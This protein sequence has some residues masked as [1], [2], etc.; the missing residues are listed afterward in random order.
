MCSVVKPLTVV[1]GNWD[2]NPRPSHSDI[3]CFSFENWSQ[4][5]EKTVGLTLN[6]NSMHIC[7]MGQFQLSLVYCTNSIARWAY[8]LKRFRVEISFASIKILTHDLLAS[9]FSWQDWLDHVFKVHVGAAEGQ[10]RSSSKTIKVE[11]GLVDL[12]EVVASPPELS[13][14]II[15][16]R[17]LSDDPKD[18]PTSEPIFRSGWWKVSDVTFR[19]NLNPSRLETKKTDNACFDPVSWLWARKSVYR[20]VRVTFS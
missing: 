9:F 14:K 17:S 19:K 4:V 8:D 1:S 6:S 13:I 11:P 7:H 5:P 16:V 20:K 12:D 10:G 3:V 18:R 2:S 15:D